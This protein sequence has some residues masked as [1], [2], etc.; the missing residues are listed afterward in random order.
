MRKAEL[1]WYQPSPMKNIL[2]LFLG[3]IIFA[4][5]VFLT[6]KSLSF[7]Q[8]HLP[9]ISSLGSEF[10]QT[11]SGRQD[12]QGSLPLEPIRYAL[13]NG[14]LRV[15]SENPRYFTDGSGRAVLLTGSHTWS[16]L[17]DSGDSDPPPVFDYTEYLDFLDSHNHNFFRLWRAENAKGGEQSNDYWFY[18]MPYQRTGSE[19][20]LD[21]K[22]KFDLTQFDQAYFDRMRERIIEAG[23]RGFYVS[24]ML[25][26]G[27]SAQSKF[28]SHN[29]WLGHPF[30]Q[31]NNI[32]NI[33]GD[34]NGNGS[35]EE[36]HTLQNP[37]ITDLQ[38]AYVR[39]V[40]DTVNDLDNVL[41]EI[42][43]ESPGDSQDWQYHMINLIK[44]YEVT[45]PKQ[46]PVGMTVEWPNGDNADLFASPA[47]W[48]SPNGDVN[49]PLAADG[50]K[51]ILSDTDHLCGVCGDRAWVWK[52][53][54][55]GE[56][57]IFMDPYDGV[58]EGRGSFPGYDPN[59]PNDVSIRKNLGYALTYA[60]RM[61]LVEMTP[62]PYLCSTGYCLAN[63]IAKGSEYLVYLP[64]GGSVNVDLSA[65]SETLKVEW[66]N[67][68]QGTKT[69][70]GTTS[71]GGVKSFTAPFGGDAVLY[72]YSTS[73][74]I[75][76]ATPVPT[77]RPEDTRKYYLPWICH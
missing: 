30:N 17:V 71:S 47:D 69:A 59:N 14:P 66:F 13:G 12:S 74:P 10:I 15:S 4:A 40:V 55:M 29:P 57:P 28:G 46:H 56:N 34:P 61:N 67:P 1:K 58:D 23:E 70:G 48:I 77:P 35:G 49:N 52:S 38:D 22:P 6:N 75:P 50:S 39:K 64:D 53:L 68:D 42:S 32:N 8:R 62:Q 11:I 54:T 37:S 16:N 33:N 60:N 7:I 9:E 2:G 21:G 43:N 26:D 41:Y 76:S 31:D 36:T 27:W 73:V 24:I 25:F 51:V 45:K 5:F 72:I 18:P 44:S 20:A 65:T 3:L 63:P 19:L